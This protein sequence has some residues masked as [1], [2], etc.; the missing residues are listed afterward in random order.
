M[1]LIS[2]QTGSIIAVAQTGVIGCKKH[3]NYMCNNIFLSQ[4]LQTYLPMTAA[5]AC[6]PNIRNKFQQC[7]YLAIQNLGK[8]RKPKI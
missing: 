2:V 3:S 1:K 8:F 7:R 4:H 6:M 5:W